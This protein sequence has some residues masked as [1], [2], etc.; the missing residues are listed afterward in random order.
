V[1]H[2]SICRCQQRSLNEGE[3]PRALEQLRERLERFIRKFFNFHD[4]DGSGHIDLG[5][6]SLL[7]T[8]LGI[9]KNSNFMSFNAM[10]ADGDGSISY[11][12]FLTTL[13]AYVENYDQ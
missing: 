1:S 3:T 5:E 4:R 12:E 9:P 8:T 7:A 11:D 2:S 6:Y 10:D 13:L